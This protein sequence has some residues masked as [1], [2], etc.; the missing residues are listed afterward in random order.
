MVVVVGQQQQQ[1]VAVVMAGSSSREAPVGASPLQTTTV[2]TLLTL[3]CGRRTT[4]EVR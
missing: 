4:W 3:G 2:R 1:A